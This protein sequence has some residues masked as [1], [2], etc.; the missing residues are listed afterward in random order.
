MTGNQLVIHC[1][2][3]SRNDQHGTVTR[4]VNRTYHLPSDV[5]TSTIKS[6]LNPRGVLT[7]TAT[8]KK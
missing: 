3:E 6:H 7:I 2:H 8:K 1:R 4:E 5:D